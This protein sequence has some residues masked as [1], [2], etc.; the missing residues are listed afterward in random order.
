MC[1]TP[2]GDNAEVRDW[3]VVNPNS[4]HQYFSNIDLPGRIVGWRAIE[5]PTVG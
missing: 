5:G 3:I 4:Q 1:L 2:S